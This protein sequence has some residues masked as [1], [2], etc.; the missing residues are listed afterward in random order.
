MSSN[1]KLRVGTLNC[2]GLRNKWKRLA[3][4]KSLREKKLDVICLQEAHINQ[5]DSYTWERQWGGKLLYN[6]GTNRSQGELILLSKLLLGELLW[7]LLL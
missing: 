5:N 4:F 1:S 7:L 6:E 3:L 2:R